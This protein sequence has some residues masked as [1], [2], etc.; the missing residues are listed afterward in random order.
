MKLFKDFILFEKDHDW[1]LG[2]ATLY[3][4]GLTDGLPV[5]LPTMEK[6]EE[7]LDFTAKNQTYGQVPPGYR[8]LTPANVAYNA[9]L[10][11]CKPQEFPVV[12]TAV[13]AS[14]KNQFNLLGIQTTTGTPTTAVMIHG[15][16]IQR[17]GLNHGTNCLGPGN[18]VNASIGRAVRLSLMNIGAAYPGQTDMATMGQP[19]K[20][21]FCFAESPENFFI[22]S[23]HTRKGLSANESAVTVI[24]VSGTVEIYDT[25]S[26]PQSILNTIIENVYTGKKNSHSSHN[27]YIGSGELFLLIPPEIIQ[28]FDA[29]EWSLKQIQQYIY[30]HS[31]ARLQIAKSPDH[32]YPVITGG[33]GIK[34]TYLQTWAGGTEAVT[35][36]LIA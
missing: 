5:F 31:N 7:M 18:R 9:I 14:T 24:G 20:Y 25:S 11:G 26:Q 23:F 1:E 35:M 8:D 33:L 10:A 29:S 19:G 36:P 3:E 34:M 6:M 17:L 13:V 16:V 4:K 27:P 21:T 30:N 12:L 2:N 22:P 28:R 15:P 32:I